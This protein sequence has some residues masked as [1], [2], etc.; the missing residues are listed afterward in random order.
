MAPSFAI[1]PDAPK[2]VL[3]SAHLDSHEPSSD[4]TLED[5]TLRLLTRTRALGR[6][7]QRDSVSQQRRARAGADEER[8]SE[9]RPSSLPL[10]AGARAAMDGRRVWLEWF[11]SDVAAPPPLDIAAVIAYCEQRVPPHAL[12]QV[13]MEAIVDRHAVTLV[14]RRAPWR[15]EF[16]PEWTRSPVARLRWS[17]SRREWTLFWRDRN[18]RWHRYKYTAPTTEIARLLE[19]IDRDPTGIFW[20]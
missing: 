15:P 14:E 3:R 20:G 10:R 11:D 7:V 16:G 19:D 17:V 4:G 13:R 8:S 6:F 1:A 9:R 2:R 5:A 18:H 12:Y